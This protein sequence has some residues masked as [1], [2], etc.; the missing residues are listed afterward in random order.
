M[1]ANSISVAQSVQ[2][3]GGTPA[4]AM[5]A[6]TPLGHLWQD[7]HSQREGFI[8]VLPPPSSLD[9]SRSSIKRQVANPGVICPPEV[10]PDNQ[11]EGV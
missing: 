2:S 11:E 7:G 4:I 9:L 10:K 6:A 3:G 8:Y 1:L 5:V